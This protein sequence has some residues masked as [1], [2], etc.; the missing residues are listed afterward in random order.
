M[1]KKNLFVLGAVACVAPAAAAGTIVSAT[2]P[3]TVTGPEF[4]AGFELSN[5]FDE[6]VADA[7]LDTTAFGAVAGTQWAGPGLGP[8][9]I[10]M[11][12][13][14]SITASGVGYAQRS[15]DTA[16]FDKVTQIEFWFSDTDFGGILPGGV[17]DATVS[18]TILD[19]TVLNEYAMGG[20]FSGR[21]VAARFT[22][23]GQQ[24]N[25]G[26]SEMRLTVPEPGSLA[27]LG[28][29][30]LMLARRRRA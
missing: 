22:A 10:F 2:G 21:Y 28:L 9:T 18:V 13:G 3:T 29:G 7:D 25:P 17:A 27:L 14:S 26:G 4:G 12:Y 20:S 5:L 16:G 23:T 24:G 30:G 1:L 11:D 8:H 6:T 19:D 15:G